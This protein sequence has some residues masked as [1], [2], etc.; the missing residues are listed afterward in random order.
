MSLRYFTAIGKVQQVMFRQ[1]LIRAAQK[2]SLRAGASNDKQDKELVHF[3]MSGDNA[4][5]DE[6][7]AFMRSGKEL[8]SWGAKA[9]EVHEHNTGKALEAHKV[10]TENVDQFNWAKEVTFYI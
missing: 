7:I 6:M 2:R 5:I 4:K 9:R 10:T 1:T 8:N 3:T